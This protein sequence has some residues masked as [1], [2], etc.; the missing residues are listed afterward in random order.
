MGYKGQL[1]FYLTGCNTLPF[2]TLSYTEASITNLLLD[3]ITCVSGDIIKETPLRKVV[4]NGSISGGVLVVPSLGVAQM[5]HIGFRLSLPR[6]LYQAF[7]LVEAGPIVNVPGETNNKAILCMVSGG[8]YW[9]KG[10]FQPYMHGGIAFN[11]GPGIGGGFLL[12]GGISYKKKI[13][14]E[15]RNVLFYLVRFNI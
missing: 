10:K 7:A 11:A 1:A 15:V 13:H 6:S 4:L 8:S 9:G 2:K 12:A 5:A 3:Y 14:L